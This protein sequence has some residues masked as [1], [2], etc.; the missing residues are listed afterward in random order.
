MK[1]K[2]PYIIGF[3]I[4]VVG[5]LLYLLD[6]SHISTTHLQEQAVANSNTI[7]DLRGELDSINFTLAN[8]LEANA[9]LQTALGAEVAQH[10]SEQEVAKSERK[11]LHE[12]IIVLQTE[13]EPL[14]QANPKL[15]AL[16]TAYEASEA[17]ATAQIVAL[18]FER[19]D[20]KKK[21]EVSQDDCR[22][23]IEAGIKKDAALKKSLDAFT[24]C[25]TDLASATKAL[26]THRKK[27]KVL[28]T[29]VLVEA[30]IILAT[31]LTK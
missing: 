9:T 10:K 5:V 1:N 15:Q 16:I 11:K 4:L 29:T 28:A 13:L 22:A 26:A 25:N 2:H 27:T 18:E 6:T 19:D 8:T 17:A 20:W 7:N 24:Q 31:V 14:I 23:L 30:G 21:F 12:Q 3:L